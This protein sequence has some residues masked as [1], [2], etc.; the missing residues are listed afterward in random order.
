MPDPAPTPTPPA[1]RHGLL[2]CLGS[3]LTL[4]AI[5]IIVAAIGFT[6]AKGCSDRERLFLD[7]IKARHPGKFAW[8]DGGDV[9][10]LECSH[11]D[12]ED[13]AWRFDTG[14]KVV[15][16]AWSRDGRTLYLVEDVGGLLSTTHRIEALDVMTSKRRVVLDLGTSK[17]E[18]DE[19]ETEEFWVGAWGEVEAEQERLYFQL[20]SGDWYSVESK[21]SRVRSEPGRP[22][23]PWD[24]A[25]CPD[26]AHRLKR[27]SDDDD[28]WLEVTDGKVAVR[29][30]RKDVDDDGAWYCER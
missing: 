4:S 18:S 29:V 19:I 3:T 27:E 12:N 23:Q 28:S 16:I 22:A 25:V 13:T 20:E 10:V 14:Q 24:Q 30:T 7:E 26:G 5:G 9:S 15:R 6:S 21:R 1:P 8:H 11:L 17:L 2:A